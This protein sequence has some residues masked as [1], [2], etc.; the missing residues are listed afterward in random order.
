M[1]AYPMKAESRLTVLH[2]EQRRDGMQYRLFYFVRCNCGTEFWV[3]AIDVKRG[4]T[5]SCGC[6]RSDIVRANQLNRGQRTR[7]LQA[8]KKMPENY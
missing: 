6:L 7:E 1:Q 8:S 3:A 2:S 4:H 5:L